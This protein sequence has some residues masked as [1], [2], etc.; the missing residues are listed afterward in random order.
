MQSRPL[1]RHAL[2]ATLAT[3]ILAGLYGCG[4]SAGP[5]PRIADRSKIVVQ[6]GRGVPK[7]CEVGMSFAEIRKATGE[8]ST[9]G[10]YDRD[11]INLKRFTHGRFV[12]VPSLGVIGIPEQKGVI[13]LLTFY[14]QPHDSSITMPGLVVT[15]PFRG[16]I[17]GGLSFS[18]HVVNRKEIET[19][20]GVVTQ[21]LTSSTQSLDS[22][23]K[24]RPFFN[25]RGSHETLYYHHLGLSFDLE[26]DTVTSFSVSKPAKLK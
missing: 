22:L 19:A 11:R 2:W 16:S 18:N 13:P 25:R 20:F 14:V 4:K 23:D 17:A 26:N 15:R 7:V 24:T 5:T 10:L 8:A 12:L 9:H 3:L 6:P 21:G 1:S